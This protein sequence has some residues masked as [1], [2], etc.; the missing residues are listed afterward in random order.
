MAKQII[1]EASIHELDEAKL[2]V[3]NS[4]LTR[5]SNL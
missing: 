1:S 2:K 5:I 4:F 3:W